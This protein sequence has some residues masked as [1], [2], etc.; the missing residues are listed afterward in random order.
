VVGN[1]N[2]LTITG[3]A[4]LGDGATDTLTG[5]GALSVSG[6]T[7]IRTTDIGSSGTQTYA[8]A[9]TLFENTTLTGSTIGQ[10]C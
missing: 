10:I 2:A 7:L 4:E 5:L 1:T 3:N 6:T 9:L 8:G